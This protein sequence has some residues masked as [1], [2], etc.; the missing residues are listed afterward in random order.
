MYDKIVD[1]L[2]AIKEDQPEL[3]QSLSPATELNNDIGL[4][5]LQ[6][7]QFMLK[8]EDQLNVIIDYDEF[9]YEHL[10]SI[11]TFITFLKSCQSQEQLLYED[12]QK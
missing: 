4:D 1:I 6:M 7:I 11:D 9:D 10:Q 12:A 8:V 5:S 3:R 2:C